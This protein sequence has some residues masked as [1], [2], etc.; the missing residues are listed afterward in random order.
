MIADALTIGAALAVL[1]WIIGIAVPRIVTLGRDWSREL[2]PRTPLY[3]VKA[4]Q[5]R[6]TRQVPVTDAV[7]RA[8][9]NTL[10]LVSTRRIH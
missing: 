9:L 2:F 7:R 10:M 8:R 6:Q 1:A 5:H 3:V 4:K